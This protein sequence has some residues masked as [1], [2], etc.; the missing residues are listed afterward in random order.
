MLEQI[1]GEFPGLW[2][3][4][5]PLTGA[6]QKASVV[7]TLEATAPTEE[8]ANTVL[9]GAVRRLLALAGGRR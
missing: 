7:V 6:K 1:A 5:R 2:V 8:V 4:S 3:S 9:A